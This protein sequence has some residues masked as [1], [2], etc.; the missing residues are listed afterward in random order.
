MFQLKGYAPGWMAQCIRCGHIKKASDYGLFRFGKRKDKFASRTCKHCKTYTT[1]K[2]YKV[3]GDMAV[4][5]TS[6][7]KLGV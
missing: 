2:L 7:R 5:K 4:V 1:L 3:Q 6:N